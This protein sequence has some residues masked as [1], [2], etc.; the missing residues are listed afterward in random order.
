[1]MRLSRVSSDRQLLSLEMEWWN[2][3]WWIRANIC[4]GTWMRF[5]Q[6]RW[7]PKIQSE[8]CFLVVSY[9]Q[10]SDYYPLNKQCKTTRSVLQTLFTQDDVA[11]SRPVNDSG[12]E[13]LIELHRS[14]S[15]CKA[16]ATAWLPGLVSAGLTSQGKSAAVLTAVGTKK[17]VGRFRQSSSYFSAYWNIICLKMKNVN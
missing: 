6:R 4:W 13:A 1:M 2:N 17:Q 7:S 3:A 5:I 10:V 8:G 12:C 16:A 14:T 11:V 15:E 9:R